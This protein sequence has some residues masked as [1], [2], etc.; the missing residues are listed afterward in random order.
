MPLTL[1]QIQELEDLAIS[2]RDQNAIRKLADAAR[3]TAVDEPMYRVVTAEG[4]IRMLTARQYL[5]MTAT[6]LEAA[7]VTLV[8][9]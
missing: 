6:D 1:K 3:E 4:E 2:K 5:S 7:S 9:K 8:E